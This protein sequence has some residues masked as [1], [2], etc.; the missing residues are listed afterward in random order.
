MMDR[1]FAVLGLVSILLLAGC[2]G[3]PQ[4]QPTPQPQPAPAP[5]PAPNVTQ[6]PLPP[7]PAQ[8]AM[9]NSTAQNQTPAMSPDSCDVQFQK[10]ASDIYTIMVST[11]SAKN[12]TVMCPNGKMAELK[13]QLY[14]CENLDI[15]SPAVALLDGKVCGSAQF[16]RQNNVNSPISCSVNA[17]PSWIVA[18]GQAT[19]TFSTSTGGQQVTASYTCGGT[20]KVVQASGITSD[21]SECTFSTPGDIEI[22][23]KINGSVCATTILHV[24]SKPKDCSVFGSTYSSSNGVY[25]YTAQLAARG[26]SSEDNILYYCY[27]TNHQ[28]PVIDIPNSTNFV[29]TLT[30]YGSA[31]MTQPVKVTVAGDDCGYIN[32]PQ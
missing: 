15:Q 18:G 26:Y 1:A 7:Q 5:A 4:Q 28:T 31:P 29:T 8:P 17:G 25:T 6:T 32:L 24:Y 3:S 12:L 20:E 22:D 30:C 11:A 19:V 9:N 21:S 13:G 14:Y 23:A 16:Q 27:G 2:A 10:D